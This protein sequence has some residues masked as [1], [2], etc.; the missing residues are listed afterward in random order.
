[1]REMID[2]GAEVPVLLL[3]DEMKRPVEEEDEED[4]AA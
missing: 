2:V 3:L 1:M 4:G